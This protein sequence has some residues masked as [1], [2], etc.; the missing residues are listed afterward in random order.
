MSLAGT[1][2]SALT[3]SGR[4]LSWPRSW[5]RTTRAWPP[6][7]AGSR[8]TARTHTWT[9]TAR[10]PVILPDG[11]ELYLLIRRQLVLQTNRQFHMQTLDFTFALEHFVQLREG[12]LF[13][14]GIALDRL[15]Q[16]FH[17]VLQL[18]L[19]FVEARRRS[20]NLSAHECLLLVSQ[21]QFALM[22]HDHIGRK[23][24]ITEGVLWWR[25]RFLSLPLRLP[26][27]VPQPAVAPWRPAPR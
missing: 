1:A 7:S 25:R 15:V 13:V 27:G 11:L 22:L 21:R 2:G 14:D 26:A 17:L 5:S 16:H 12:K 4:S 24:R 8:S 18:P 3:A 6:R 23:D 10:R 20:L 9:I 19:K